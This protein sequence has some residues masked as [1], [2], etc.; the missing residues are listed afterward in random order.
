MIIN[1][2]TSAADLLPTTLMA[3]SKSSSKS[4]A[5]AVGADQAQPEPVSNQ[6]LTAAG[7]PITDED[8]AIETTESMRQMIIAQNSMAMMTQANSVPLRALG[9]LQ[10]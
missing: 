1:S 4:S 8:T 3:R 5:A 2:N 9:L 7:A 10:Q 6:N